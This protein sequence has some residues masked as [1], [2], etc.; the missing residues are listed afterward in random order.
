MSEKDNLEIHINDLKKKIEEVEAIRKQQVVYAKKHEKEYSDYL[1][2]LRKELKHDE[3]EL[4]KMSGRK[5]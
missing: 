1:R 2:E 5:Q 4:E 3:K